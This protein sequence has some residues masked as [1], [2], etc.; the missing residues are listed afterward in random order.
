MVLYGLKINCHVCIFFLTGLAHI[1]SKTVEDIF[2][3]VLQGPEGQAEAPPQPAQPS[4]PL[5]PQHP[6]SVHPE[7]HPGRPVKQK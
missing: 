3:G 6:P 4:H 7:H 1:D 2:K 5:P